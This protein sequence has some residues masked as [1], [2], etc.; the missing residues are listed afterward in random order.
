MAKDAKEQ[1][2]KPTNTLE[3]ISLTIVT[4]TKHLKLHIQDIGEI[5]EQLAATKGK[6]ADVIKPIVEFAQAAKNVYGD[7]HAVFINRDT[8]AHL[9]DEF[10]QQAKSEQ[11]D[12]AHAAHNKR[13]AQDVAAPADKAEDDK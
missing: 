13:G 10:P 3:S 8:I 12:K 5:R 9:S 7:G 6:V 1:K 11:F 4:G 2:P